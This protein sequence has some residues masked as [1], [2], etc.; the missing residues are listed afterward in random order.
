[1]LAT[2]DK[3]APYNASIMELLDVIPSLQN[4]LVAQTATKRPPAKLA[5]PQANESGLSTVPH[6][7]QRPLR[8]IFWQSPK[9]AHTWRGFS[10]FQNN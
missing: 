3:S 1:M 2:L 9:L 7:T 6:G 10:L 4:F 5:P 8:P